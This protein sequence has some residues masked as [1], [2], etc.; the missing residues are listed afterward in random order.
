MLIRSKLK[1][2]I[3]RI[4]PLAIVSAYVLGICEFLIRR[5]LE[6]EFPGIAIGP[7]Y[8]IILLSLF[9][10]IMGLYQWFRYRLWVYP[11]VGFL[12]TTSTFQSLSNY[13]LFHIP[14]LHPEGYF[15]NIFLV[16]IFVIFFWPTFAGAER[17]ETNARRL[18]KLAAELFYDT[19]DG[20]TDRPFSAGTTRYT[21]EELMGFARFVNGKFIARSYYKENCVYLGFSLGKSPVIAQDPTEIS[22]VRLD[23]EGNITVSISAFDYRQYREK[24]SFDQLCASIGNIFKRFLEYYKDGNE[25]RIITELKTAR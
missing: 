6:K 20:Y 24:F 12:A 1:G 16:I 4:Y 10:F 9:F 17:F 2:P 8:T 5:M 22:Y 18:L 13:H 3:G 11:V 25:V 23:H 19:S 14:Y 15:I 7:I 21:S